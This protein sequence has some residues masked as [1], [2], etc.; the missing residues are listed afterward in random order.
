M[1]PIER[2]EDGYKYRAYKIDGRATGSKIVQN[3]IG[4]AFEFVVV[5]WEH[6]NYG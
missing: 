1:K 5:E 6:P 4:A 2:K 3:F